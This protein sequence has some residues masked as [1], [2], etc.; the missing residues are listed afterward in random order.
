VYHGR[1]H[2]PTWDEAMGFAM[3]YEGRA[4]R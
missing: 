2:F 1:K 4:V 3:N